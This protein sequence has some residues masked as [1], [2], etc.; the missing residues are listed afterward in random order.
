MPWQGLG[1]PLSSSL[2]SSGAFTPPPKTPCLWVGS[3][4][5]YLLRRSQVR[6]R[7][8]GPLWG[9]ASGS[10]PLPTSG[11]GEVRSPQSTPM[12]K[13]AMAGYAKREARQWL[14]VHLGRRQP[15]PHSCPHQEPENAMLPP[16]PHPLP[17]LGAFPEC[18]EALRRREQ[19]TCFL[20]SSQGDGI[21]PGGGLWPG[22]TA[23]GAPPLG[24][25]SL[26]AACSTWAGTT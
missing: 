13:V 16:S 6:R 18:W 8:D 5:G 17:P 24:E 15:P 3:P 7:A 26:E 14:L 12:A 4:I 2:G 23:A 22:R 10:P 11:G 1:W 25:L 19:R 21:Q 20:S 9:I